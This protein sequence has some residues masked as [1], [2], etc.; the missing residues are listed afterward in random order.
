MNAG[1]LLFGRVLV[2]LLFAY[3][4]Y[5]KLVGYQGTVNYFAKWQ[6]PAPEA[7]AVLAIVIEL[8]G[9]ILLLIGW[10]TRWLAWLLALHVLIATAVA[11]RFWTYEAAQQFAQTSFFFKNLAIVGALLIIAAAGPGRIS[12]DRR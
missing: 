3:F 6:F 1:L 8:G 4:G 10:K 11:H 9:G 5:L 12:L 2:A 7:T